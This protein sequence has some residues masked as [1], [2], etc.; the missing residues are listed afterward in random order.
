M[1][2]ILAFSILVTKIAMTA[3][4]GMRLEPRGF[5]E[6]AWGGCIGATG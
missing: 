2:T 4:V 3:L 1:K 5:A 6:H